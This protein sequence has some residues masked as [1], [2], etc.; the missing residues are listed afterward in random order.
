MYNKQHLLDIMQEREKKK[1]YRLTER[2]RFKGSDS[3]QEIML[4][5]NVYISIIN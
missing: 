3:S 5:D 4:L 1:K 2:K